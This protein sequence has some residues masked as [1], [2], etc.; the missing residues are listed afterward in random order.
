[1]L[2]DLDVSC[3]G[4]AIA[5][6]LE[7]AIFD[8]GATWA[9]LLMYERVNESYQDYSWDGNLFATTGWVCTDCSSVTESSELW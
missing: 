9:G 2:E 6:G 4:I 7:A 8:A 1:M 3:S 5:T